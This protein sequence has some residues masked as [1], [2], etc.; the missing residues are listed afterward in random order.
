MTPTQRV[1]KAEV[2]LYALLAQP[3]R[4]R[5]EISDA[6]CSV[7]STAQIAARNNGGIAVNHGHQ[8]LRDT[9]PGRWLKFEESVWTTIAR[10]HA[11]GVIWQTLREEMILL[12]LEARSIEDV[13][14]EFE[15]NKAAAA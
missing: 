14:L 6:L 2:A 4:C 7:V 1:H 9:N 3:F 15:Q 8:N 5:P 13:R 12:G 11:P 10:G